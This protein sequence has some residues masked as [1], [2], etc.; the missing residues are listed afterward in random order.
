MSSRSE[1][2][3]RYVGIDVS[4]GRLDVAVRRDGTHEDRFGVANDQ[5]G[6]G[7]LVA[8]LAPEE[9][10][11]AL[12]VLESSGGFERPA[13]TTLARE[14]LAVA[15]VNPRQ[16]RDFARATGRLAKT[17]R[18]DAEILARFAEAVRPEPRALPDEEALLLGEILDRRRQLVGMLVTEKNRLGTVANEPVKGRI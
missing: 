15:V 5:E 4:K 16:T 2:L 1:P 14:G 9:R 7:A 13:A 11:V 12:V 17:D 6:I 10:P 3:S 18:L 8:R